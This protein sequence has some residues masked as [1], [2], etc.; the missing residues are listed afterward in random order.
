[1]TALGIQR[2]RS[3]SAALCCFAGAYLVARWFYHLNGLS[4][5]FFGTIGV[6]LVGISLL[7]S[8]W[9]ASELVSLRTN[10]RL[11]VGWLLVVGGA[12]AASFLAWFASRG[13]I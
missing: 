11:V 4:R 10:A 5:M 8:R 6:A 13:G 1:M 2:L 9:G 3:I 12:T 7:L